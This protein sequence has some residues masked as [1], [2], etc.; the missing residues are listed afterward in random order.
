MSGSSDAFVRHGVVVLA[1]GATQADPGMVPKHTGPGMYT[2]QGFQKI[3]D[4]G[5]IDTQSPLQ[6]AMI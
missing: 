1:V 3:L 6:V 2:Q 4:N 5:E